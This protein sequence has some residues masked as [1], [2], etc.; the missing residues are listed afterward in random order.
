[1]TGALRIVVADDE[2]DMFDFYQTM[3]TGQGHDVVATAENGQQ[4]VDLALQHEP[5]LIITDIRMPE[6]DGLSAV[7]EITSR[8]PVAAIVV[9]A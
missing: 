2:P 9:S 3:L 6:L 8:N 1:M 4:L 5:D 7:R